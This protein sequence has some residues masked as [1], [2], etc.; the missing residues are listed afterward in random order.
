MEASALTLR[1]DEFSYHFLISKELR[2]A[3]MISFRRF[4]PS[5]TFLSSFTKDFQSI[6]LGFILA[7]KVVLLNLFSL[8]AFFVLF[9]LGQ[10]LS[11]LTLYKLHLQSCLA[12]SSCSEWEL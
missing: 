11:H 2:L 9:Q 5:Q 6:R 4:E 1:V 12:I 7:W 10:S 3:E 8:F